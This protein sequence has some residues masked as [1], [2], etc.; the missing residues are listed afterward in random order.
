MQTTIKPSL[1]LEGKVFQIQEKRM[2]INIVNVKGL[3]SH[4][5]VE[6]C[7]VGWQHFTESRIRPYIAERKGSSFNSFLHTKTGPLES[8][9][10]RNLPRDDT[11]LLKLGQK[12]SKMFVHDLT[13]L[14]R[15]DNNH[16]IIHPETTYITLNHSYNKKKKKLLN[17]NQNPTIQFSPFIYY[18]NEKYYFFSFEVS[19]W[20]KIEQK[21]KKSEFSVEEFFK[22]VM[23]E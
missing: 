20:K 4:L 8:F 21:K 11:T 9:S 18:E 22:G 17:L 1:G 12:S 3:K 7:S 10:C 5:R 2:I 19:C 16:K 23:N 15:I 14:D 6:C 13:G